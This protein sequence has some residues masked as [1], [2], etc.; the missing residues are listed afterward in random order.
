MESDRKTAAALEAK[1]MPRRFCPNSSGP[2]VMTGGWTVAGILHRLSSGER[3][4]W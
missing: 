4:G 3:Q 2:K 1:G